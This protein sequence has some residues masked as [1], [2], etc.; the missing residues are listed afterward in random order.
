MK[1]RDYGQFPLKALREPEVSALPYMW[2]YSYNHYMPAW[3]HLSMQKYKIIDPF[4]TLT[5]HKFMANR[6]PG[7]QKTRNSAK[8][9]PGGAKRV[10]VSMVF[11]IL[12]FIVLI[13][14][15]FVLLPMVK[16]GITFPQKQN[17]TEQPE[18]EEPGVQE[19]AVQKPDPQPKAQEKSPEK[20]P[21][22]P[23]ANPPAATAKETPQE[24]APPEKPPAKPPEQTSPQSG[25]QQSSKQPDTQPE[26][27]PA[28]T[29]DRS[30]YFMQESSGGAD[31]ALVKVNRKLAVSD[32]PLLD[33]INALLAGPTAEERNRGLINFIPQN[34]R[35]LSARVDNN[36]VILNFNEEFRYNT[37]G[38]EGGAAQLKQ[39]VWTATEFPNVH[40]VQI[41]I[42]GKTVDFL[43]EGITIRNPIGRS[44]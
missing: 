18:A 20:A 39:I 5:Y 7:T 10:S 13:I 44:R 16:K 30:I 40:D 42:E 1:A 8:K 25:T 31:L 17:V 14:I 12:F 26:R 2:I 41:Q 38:R 34:A 23:P 19:P 32:S 36:T 15:F 22:K 28:E 11:W 43:I 6:R 3:I 24:K 27:K 29:R 37:F 33:S 21:E 35:I 4:L 9:S